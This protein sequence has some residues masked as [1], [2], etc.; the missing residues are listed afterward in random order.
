MRC[1]LSGRSVNTLWS[2]WVKSSSYSSLR[3]NPRKWEVG[4]VTQHRTSFKWTQIQNSELNSHS[5]SQLYNIEF[6][7]YILS[8]CNTCINS[9]IIYFFF[10]KRLQRPGRNGSFT[11][12]AYEFS[13]GNVGGC[14]CHVS[15]CELI[16]KFYSSQ[17]M[18]QWVC[19]DNEAMF[20]LKSI[21]L[22]QIIL[23]KYKVRSN[24]DYSIHFI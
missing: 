15:A 11:G 8:A 10:L 6:W 22:A 13:G 23:Y 21:K 20:L 7:C 4:Q 16:L 1:S 5:Y 12:R 3:P 17:V 24:S 9:W 14:S 2:T 18:Y 19:L